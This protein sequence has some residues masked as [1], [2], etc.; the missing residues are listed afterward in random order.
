MARQGRSDLDGIHILLFAAGSSSRMAGRDK[1][2]E[3]IAGEPLLQRSARRAL[4]TGLPVTAVLRPDR[5]DRV[6][7]LQGTDIATVTAARAAE[8]MAHS[9]RAGLES[10]PD[11]TCG[12][13]MLMADM[14]ELDTPDL[15][16][17][18]AR[19][20]DLGCDTV[21]RAA[22]SDGTPGSPAIVPRRLFAP[23]ANLEGDTGGRDVL[24]KEQQEIVRLPGRHALTDL[25]TPEDWR[26]WRQ[27][28]D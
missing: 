9:I 20:R 17:L 25:D 2:L 19:F 12:A 28:P 22:A 21:V 6:S 23:L 13:M 18:V 27:S 24:R 7:V 1:L 16:M 10:L 14:P 8:G 4:A 5:P 3:E 11:T 26:H 15:L